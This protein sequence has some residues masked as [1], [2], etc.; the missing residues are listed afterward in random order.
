MITPI[1]N[2]HSKKGVHSKFK[3]DLKG[4]VP[5]RLTVWHDSQLNT[6]NM[7]RQRRG[8]TFSV[9]N[10]SVIY[11]QVLRIFTRIKPLT[12]TGSS[13]HSPSYQTT[14]SLV[15][16]SW[17]NLYEHSEYPSTSQHPLCTFNGYTHIQIKTLVRLMRK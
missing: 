10:K 11:V 7:S 1:S 16:S 17:K 2:Y 12:Q 13:W 9:V 4:G 6:S 3:W 14:R 15:M 8:R 5:R